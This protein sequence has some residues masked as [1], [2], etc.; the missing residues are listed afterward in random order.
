MISLSNLQNSL[1][2]TIV[3][4]KREKKSSLTKDTRIKSLEDIVIRLGTD[5]NDANVV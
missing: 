2:K 4:L 3:E 1:S 5:P